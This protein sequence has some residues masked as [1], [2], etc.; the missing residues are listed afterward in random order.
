M[1]LINSFSPSLF[2]VYWPEPRLQLFAVS[3]QP[4][5]SVCFFLS[6]ALEADS[7]TTLTESHTTVLFNIQM[8]YLGYSSWECGE[9]DTTAAFLES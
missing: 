2:S 3:A 5:W 1:K 9:Y 7:E 4:R 6:V 8:K